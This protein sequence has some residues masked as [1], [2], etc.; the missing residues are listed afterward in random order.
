[1]AADPTGGAEQLVYANWAR[2][3]AGPFDLSLDFGYNTEGGPP[4][5]FPVRVA[6]SWEHAK[7]LHRLIGEAMDGYEEQAGA[8]RKLVDEVEV[9]DDPS[10]AND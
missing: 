10:E 6:M 7:L 8:I 3:I 2:Y 1:M 4:E 9:T 5:K